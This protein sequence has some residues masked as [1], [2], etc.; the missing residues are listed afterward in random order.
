LNQ[1]APRTVRV[2]RFRIATL[3]A[4]VA[5]V[6]LASAPSALAV[7]P[8]GDFTFAP[9]APGPGET[10]TFTAD[11]TDWGGTDPG[12]VQWNFGDGSAGAMG[13]SV[14]HSYPTTGTR[15]VTMR[16]TNGSSEVLV[17]QHDVTLPNIPP[18][19]SF[20]FGPASPF[21]GDEVQFAS[22]SYDPGGSI[23][24]YDW[25][26]G[27]G[28]SSPQANPRHPYGSPGTKTVTLTVTDDDGATTTATQQLVVAMP[29][30]PVNQPPVA[31]FAFSP[32]KPKAGQ[33][34]ELVSSAFDPEG[35]LQE[36]RWDLDG[37]GQFD[38]ARGDDVL[39]TFPS[40]GAKTVRLRV[41]D[42]LGAAAVKERTVEVAAGQKARAGFLNPFPVVRITGE[43]RGGGALIRLLT[44]R[45]PRGTFT[46]VNCDG[47]GCPAKVRRHR[48]GK[49]HLVRFKAYER[50]LQVGVKLEVYARKAGTIGKY[51]R[52]TIRAHASPKRIDRC[53]M[54]GRSKPVRCQT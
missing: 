48:V 53:L 38:D 11:I 29:A 44:V 30:G 17:V 47:R 41:E 33:Q 49:K 24:D 5:A 22:S 54:P 21:P 45:A 14:T 15:T 26:F 16:A 20:S 34:V 37:D 6:V 9:A 3:A 12:T 13:A 36:Q 4:A 40:A 7:T 51:T 23:S 8:S 43:V 50:M 1:T 25:D 18:V 35:K 39:Y 10:I 28:A 32:S 2:C 19:A 27:D 31:N 42:A 52:F 46:R